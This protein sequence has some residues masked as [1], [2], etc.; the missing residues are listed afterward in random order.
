MSVVGHGVEVCTSTTRPASPSVGQAILETDTNN[1]LIWVGDAWWVY[2]RGL[3]GDTQFMAN[4]GVS[5]SAQPSIVAQDSGGLIYFTGSFNVTGGGSNLARVSQTGVLDTAYMS[6]VANGPNSSPTWIAFQPDGKAIVVGNFATWG[7]VTVNGIVRL[8]TD[9]S[10]DAT[11]TTNVGSAGGSGNSFRCAVQSDGKIIVVGSFTTWNGVASMN[12]IV[13]L[14][15]D[16][17]RDTTFSTNVGSAANS[18]LT[19]VF[20]SASGEIYVSGFGSTWNGTSVL[21]YLIKLSS[22]GV[23][24]TTFHTNLGAGPNSIVSS[25]VFQ[26]SGKI[27]LGGQFTSIS[28]TSVGRLARLNASGSLDTSFNTGGSGLNGLVNTVINQP[29]GKL[30][31]AGSFTSW[32]GRSVSPQNIMRFTSEGVRDPSLDDAAGLGPNTQVSSASQTPA[33]DKTILAVATGT[34]TFNRAILPSCVMRINY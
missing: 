18:D 11:F 3:K 15:S 4:L 13:R 20:L 30:F 17:T 2:E 23:R 6:N 21:N 12:R 28:G 22:S 25:L 19:W 29:D 10:R 5:F 31:V 9:G 34:A 24:D 7:T 26:S 16:G 14:N 27:V 8:N 33:G 1:F 32:N